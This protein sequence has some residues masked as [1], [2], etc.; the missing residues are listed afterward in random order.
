MLQELIPNFVA[1]LTFDRAAM[2]E[3]ILGMQ[4]AVELIE[5]QSAIQDETACDK[6]MDRRWLRT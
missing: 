5:E 2:Q 3:A 1:P 4:I 6:F